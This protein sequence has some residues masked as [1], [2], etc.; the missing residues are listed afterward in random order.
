LS[1]A[2]QPH[3]SDACAPARAHRS[4]A[5]LE[6]YRHCVERHL[7]AAL[8]ERTGLVD[9]PQAAAA[10][11]R[12]ALALG[13]RHRAEA[14]VAATECLALDLPGFPCLQ[15]AAA[16]ARGLCERDP[17]S[18]EHA[19]R[20]YSDPWAR[21]SAAEDAG[22]VAAEQGAL[23]SAVAVLRHAR[24]TYADAAAQVDVD[25]VR[26]RLRR[27]GVRD[28]HG[29]YPTRPLLGWESLTDT[30]RRVAG[31]VARG[32]TNSAVAAQL[33]LSRH[34][35]AHHLRRIFRK[36]DIG[37]RVELTRVAVEQSALSPETR[38]YG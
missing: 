17:D 11:V 27:L 34:T 4:A 2:D 13:D 12:A 5:D 26:A 8:F 19:A 6:R 18:L 30:E 33:F 14:V 15:A 28:G 16:H 35:V 37:S 21:A 7:Q 3:S 29:S 38:R 36:L 9:Q 10:W 20:T 24:D 32:L 31:L 25:R 23:D 22:V 1:A